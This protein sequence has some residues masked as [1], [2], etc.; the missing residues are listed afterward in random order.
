MSLKQKFKLIRSIG[1]GQ[2]IFNC[3]F[4]L[5]RKQ[6]PSFP[7]HFT[8]IIIKPKNI[9]YHNDLITLKSMAVSS[10]CYFQ[11][12][13]GIHLGP[14]CLFAPGVKLISSNHDIGSV[15][16]KSMVTNEIIIGSDVWI[17][18]NAIILP[19][20]S[21]ADGVVIGAASVVTKSISIPGSVVAGNPARLIHS[22]RN[23][24]EK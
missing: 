20:V 17:G 18:A 4:W 12:N 23:N 8:S 7:I 13:N 3:V 10:S 16:R 24:Q 14:R 2:F 1:L 19:G 6:W 15:E 22:S 11:A 9:S 5:F 21:I